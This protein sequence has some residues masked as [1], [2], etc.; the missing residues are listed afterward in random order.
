MQSDLV[1][2]TC[3][4]SDNIGKSAKELISLRILEKLF[5][6]KIWNSDN[7]A[8][9]AHPKIRFDSSQRCENVLKHI[10]QEVLNFILV[11]EHLITKFKII[12]K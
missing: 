12:S 8:F 6:K 3:E 10:L 11:A 5:V 9:E 7:T 1:T 4:I 2:R